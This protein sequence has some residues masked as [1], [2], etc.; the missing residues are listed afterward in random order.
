MGSAMDFSSLSVS[1]PET[2]NYR[3]RS[4]FRA[5]RFRGIRSE[6]KRFDVVIAGAGII[7]LTIARR[8]LLG[9]N[10]SV[11]VVDSAVPCAGATGAGQGYIWRVHKSPEN[12]KWELALRSHQLWEDLASTVQN[13]GLDPSST[14]GWMKT[15]SLLVGS[16]SEDCSVLQ[17]K[18]QKLRDSGVD[19][20][21][22][23][24]DDLLVEEP[25][26]ELNE[27]GGAAFVPDDCQ[28]D[29]KRAVAFIEKENRACDRYAEFYHDPVINLLRSES[30]GDVEGVQTSKNRLL[31]NKAVV[32][33]TGSWSG[34]LIH[35]LLKDFPIELDIPIMP[36]K[37]HLLV[38]GNIIDSFKLNHGLMEL[39][40]GT[41]ESAIV[42]SGD[43]SVSMTA[44]MD[45]SG[46]VVLCGGRVPRQLVGFNTEVEE[47]I[48]RRIWNRAA[49]FFPA[50]RRY[51]LTDLIRSREVRVGLRPY[52][53]SGKPV[54]SPVPGLRKMF[55]A[56][57]HEGE[58]LSMS[59][60]TAEMV[61]DMILENSLKVNPSPFSL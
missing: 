58:G 13:Q 12:E 5:A 21:F 55:I 52:I 53:A 24:H 20:K 2:A 36:R 16:T 14:L 33:A 1:Q 18:V 3:W 49:E 26:L 10:L 60:G 28:I 37:G 22:L 9:S 32:V 54:I 38:L 19:A 51:S 47:S 39:G 8:F 35:G 40:Y 31:C 61:F 6:S 56:A 42:K 17:E 7:G 30:S 29:A 46:R 4:S 57:G 34:S 27:E 43:A 15:G 50:M 59:W 45:S 48:I 25:A 41:H 44:T 23:S 11:A